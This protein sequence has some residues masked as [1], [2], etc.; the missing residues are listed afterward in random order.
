[1]VGYRRYWKVLSITMLPA[2]LTLD[3]TLERVEGHPANRR[4]EVPVGPQ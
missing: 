3:I 1:L 4:H 2:L